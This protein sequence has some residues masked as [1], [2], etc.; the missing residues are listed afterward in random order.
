[1]LSVSRRFNP[2]QQCVI[3]SQSLLNFVAGAAIGA[4]VLVPI[5]GPAM[6]GLLSAK[7]I[8]HIGIITCD[9]GAR[10]VIPLA[11]GLWAVRDGGLV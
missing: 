5:F 1:M 2:Q 4:T 6:T 8:G 7:L 9:V 11:S 10:A 3:D